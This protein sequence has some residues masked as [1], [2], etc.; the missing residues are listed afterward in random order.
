MDTEVDDTL[1][2]GD[3]LSL[4]VRVE[5]GEED[6]GAVL[7][8]DRTV[9]CTSGDGV[10]EL[11][12]S[13]D[14][15]AALVSDVTVVVVLSR[16]LPKV[17]PDVIVVDP[18]DE[19]L[20]VSVPE[21]GSVE[22]VVLTEVG[23]AEDEMEEVSDSVVD[24]LTELEVCSDVGIEGIEDVPEDAA[25][26]DGVVW[27]VVDVMG[28]LLESGVVGAV[29]VVGMLVCT[30]VGEELVGLLAAGVVPLDNVEGPDD[31]VR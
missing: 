29:V 7:V 22:T 4:L 20:T 23:P 26:V 2:D 21:V 28:W 18:P 16:L 6:V 12:E 30:G 24:G 17:L 25:D 27:L 14:E 5:V 1:D 11:L 13:V 19:V 3:V 31:V 10:L 15:T 9:D 8:D